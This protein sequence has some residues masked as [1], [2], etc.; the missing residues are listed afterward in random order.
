VSL[1]VTFYGYLAGSS[2]LDRVLVEVLGFNR[3]SG[4]AFGPF[5]TLLGLIYSI[6]LG[7]IYG[8]YFDRQGAIQDALYDELSALSSL[9]DTTLFLSDK[10]PAIP[11]GRLMGI[12]HDQ[13]VFLLTYGLRSEV[14]LQSRST[15]ELLVIIDQLEAGG[16]S[17]D[18]L[19]IAGRAGGCD[20]DPSRHSHIRIL[21]HC[22]L[23]LLLMLQAVPTRPLLPPSFPLCAPSLPLSLGARAR[24]LS[25]SLSLFSLSPSLPLS[26]SPSVFPV[27][28]CQAVSTV[29]GARSRRISAIAA[30]LPLIQTVAQRIITA[31]V[32]SFSFCPRTRATS[33]HIFCTSPPLPA[34][35]PARL[36]PGAGRL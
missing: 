32:A 24:S 22:R 16:A 5:V 36:S 12:L 30:E 29:T 34:K 4:D 21:A 35:I 15:R 17:G 19:R 11:R 9:K 23:L 18:I 33:L 1:P 20:S 6:L 13:A 28:R 3:A 14:R 2:L 26:L 31:V 10:Y 25:L 8:Y 27:S 7:Q